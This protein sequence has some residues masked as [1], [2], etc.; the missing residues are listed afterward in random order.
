MS[1]IDLQQQD[2]VAIVRLNRPEKLNSLTGE[3]IRSLGDLFRGFASDSSLRAVILTGTGEKAF[4]VGTDI[5]ELTASDKAE[6]LKISL[7]GQALC[8]LIEQCPVPVIA[9]LNGLAVG[10]G[11]EL[12]LACHI[13]L[14]TA[15]VRFSLPETRLGIMPGYGGTQRMP[16]EV[17]KSRALE[18]MLGGREVSA[19]DAERLGLINR[20]VEPEDLLTESHSLAQDVA[21][22]APLA[23]RACLESVRVGL[24]LPLDEGLAVE[25]RLFAELFATAD[26]REGT[27]AFLEKRAPRF[28]GE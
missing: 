11:C 23:I 5:N 12:A 24:E 13:R 21:R 1:F 16:R 15:N 6:A 22:L 26:V 7:R 14:G 9:A 17:G 20:I 25:S 27:R 3:M 19:A 8:D 4:C 28:K 10:G 18:I 2:G